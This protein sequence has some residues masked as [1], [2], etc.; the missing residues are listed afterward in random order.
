MGQD[1]TSMF[2]A[3]M[4]LS[5]FVRRAPTHVVHEGLTSLMLALVLG[6]AETGATVAYLFL[7]RLMR[8]ISKK[9]SKMSGFQPRRVVASN[10]QS[11]S[12]DGR[13]LTY[14]HREFDTGEHETIVTTNVPPPNVVGTHSA[15]HILP[16]G[17]TVSY[18]IY[19]LKD[20]SQEVRMH[21]GNI[22]DIPS[23]VVRHHQQRIQS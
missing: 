4:F 22:D 8:K 5:I 10:S 3:E 14:T 19:T 13:T 11:H 9:S 12:I 2:L 23:S 18:T 17:R 6:D 16:D 15:S 20:G 1:D 21:S 7:K